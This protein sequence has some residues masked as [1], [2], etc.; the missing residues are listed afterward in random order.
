MSNIIM[1]MLPLVVTP[2][3][4]RLY[5][6]EAFGEWG[7]FSSFVAIVT[8]CIF[9]GFENV[10]IQAKIDELPQIINLCVITSL[11]SIAVISIIMRVGIIEGIHFFADFPNP[12]ILIVYLLFYAIYTILYNIA[13]R[14]ELYYTLSFAN[15]V[16]GGSQAV[17]RITLAFAC[18]QT[19]NGLILGTTIAQGCTAFFIL[20]FLL[21][22]NIMNLCTERS[23]T[24]IKQLASSYRNFPL[25]DA[26]AS[27]LSFAAFNLPVI[28]LSFYF[29]KATI[30][31][32]SIVLQLLLMP[33]SLVGSAMGKVYYQRISADCSSIEK[34]TKE[35]MKIITIISVLPMLFIACGGDKLI[36]LFLGSQWESAGKVALCLSLWSFPTIL[37]QPFLPLFR[38]KNKQSTLLFFDILY[39]ILG[40]GCILISC[41]L[42]TNLYIILIVF[43]SACFIVKSVLFLGI[44]S[45]SGLKN[46]SYTKAIPLWAISLTFL[47]LRLISI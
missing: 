32:F 37:T 11:C 36:V 39:F 31:C 44:V 34:T 15:I 1:Y 28:I 7:V 27:V 35:M 30:G 41:Q 40:I 6:P 42:T 47:T 13:N 9:C 25:Y 26:P 20:F 8:I 46:Y 43:S 33:M 38:V 29:E 4:T 17:F 3:L 2:I 10:I 14:F 12:C 45:T 18:L 24:K 22:K 23:L 19:I 21:R 16:Q 5:T